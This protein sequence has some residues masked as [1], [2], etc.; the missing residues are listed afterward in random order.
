M[1]AAQVSSSPTDTPTDPPTTSFDQQVDRLLTLGYPGLAGLDEAGF[2]ALV[3]PLRD[4][5][6]DLPPPSGP[7]SLP[8]VIV[9]RSTSVSTT[10]ALGRV[11]DG[12]GK[13]AVVNMDPTGPD[14]F[15]PVAGLELPDRAAY[16]L[17]DVELGADSLGVAPQDALPVIESRGRIP[18]T[19]DEGVA[20]LTQHPDILQSHHA[21]Q[22]LASRQQS[23]RIPSIWRSYGQPRL[24]WCWYGS[25]HSWMGSASA[26]ARLG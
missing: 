19:I 8:F 10:D 17:A 26:A 24:G 6:P 1:S 14:E 15:A 7:T 13:Q 25:P 16:L 23:K 4:L 12:R 9:V 3:A 21:Y 22:L 5:L 2:G 18:L 20:V 11:V